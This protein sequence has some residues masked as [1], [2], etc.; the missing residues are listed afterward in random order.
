MVGRG[1]NHDKVLKEDALVQIRALRGESRTEEGEK[2]KG[3]QDKEG[4][5]GS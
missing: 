2:L 4:D 1:E 5:H 3:M